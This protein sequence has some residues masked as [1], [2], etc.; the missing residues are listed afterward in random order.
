[1]VTWQ[2]YFA[3]HHAA[4]PLVRL[5]RFFESSAAKLGQ[6][7]QPMTSAKPWTLNGTERH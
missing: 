5:V 4:T 3:A 6:R 7:P 2:V 1:M